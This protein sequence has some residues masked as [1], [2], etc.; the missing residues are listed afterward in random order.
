[1]IYVLDDP[2]LVEDFCRE[3]I[4]LHRLYG[5]AFS[6]VWGGVNRGF[7]GA[8]NLGAE[9]AQAHANVKAFTALWKAEVLP[10][11]AMQLPTSAQGDN[12]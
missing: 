6:W 11:L 9:V 2:G 5:L 12:D 8:N 10:A 1:M 3:A 4:E 7:A